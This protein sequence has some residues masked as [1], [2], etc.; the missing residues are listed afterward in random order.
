MSLYL[1]QK[2]KKHFK[3][4]LLHYKLGHLKN[5]DKDKIPEYEKEVNKIL[6]SKEV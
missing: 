3:H 1:I 4:E 6:N 2:K 5:F